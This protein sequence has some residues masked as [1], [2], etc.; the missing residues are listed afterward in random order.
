MTICP[1]K[2]TTQKIIMLLKILQHSD[3][4][5]V[6]DYV[7]RLPDGK[8]YTVEI[9][10]K[11]EKRTIDQNRLYWL[12]LSCIM[13]ETGEHKDALHEF[14]KSYFLG[15]TENFVFD[16]YQV[17]IPNSTTKLNTKE[18]TDYLERVQQFAN[19][20]LGIVLPNPE[21]LYWEE[22]YNHYEN[23]I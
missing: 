4:Q 10:R 18:M 20:E 19:V 12:W 13:D 3:K 22:F 21:D 1:F 7:T 6:I 5:K 14:F 15:V 11:R 17:V 16:K 2:K 9:K 23:F 8:Q